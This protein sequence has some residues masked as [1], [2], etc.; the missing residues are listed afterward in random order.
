MLRDLCAVLGDRNG[1]VFREMTKVHE[2]ALRGT[3]SRLTEQMHEDRSRGE[4]VVLVEGAEEGPT[5]DVS[6]DSELR[7]RIETL[8]QR[9]DLSLR[10]VARKLSLEQGVAY[11]HIYRMCLSVKASQRNP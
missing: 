11:R 5:V 6:K 7:K 2:E 1:V 4:I 10:D 8:L 3:L 9:G